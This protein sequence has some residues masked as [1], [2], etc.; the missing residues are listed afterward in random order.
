[1]STLFT[2]CT[3]WTLHAGQAVAAD[4]R[5]HDL[6]EPDLHAVLVLADEIDHR[7]R[8]RHG[9]IGRI[10]FERAVGRR[11]LD[12]DRV[13]Q[14]DADPGFARDLERAEL[15]GL[16]AADGRIARRRAH[17]TSRTAS[18]ATTAITHVTSSSANAAQL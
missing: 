13:A 14:H 17:R 11:D 1:M 6:V 8:H 4:H 2:S 15:E 10:A 9:R 18:A 5:V 12:D 3:W 16:G 7:G